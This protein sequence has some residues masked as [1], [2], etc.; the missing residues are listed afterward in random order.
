MR[1]L[2]LCSALALFAAGCANEPAEVETP[3]GEAEVVTEPAEDLT[4]DDLLLDDAEV[5]A[6]DLVV[7]DST[8]VEGDMGEDL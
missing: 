1:S 6:D 3:L 7:D 2:L 4:D 8:L 5:P